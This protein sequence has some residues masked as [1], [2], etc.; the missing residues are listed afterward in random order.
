[1]VNDNYQ[2]D[3]RVFYT[4]IP[5]KLFGRLLDI[6]P[7]NFIFLETTF[8]SEFHYTKVSLTDQNSKMLE[9]EVKVN[10]TLVIN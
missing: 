1:M 7:K 6:S 3:S 4:L 8:N 2:Q 10:I 9:I 5:N